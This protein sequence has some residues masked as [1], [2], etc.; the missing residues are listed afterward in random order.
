MKMLGLELPRPTHKD[1]L[2][3]VSGAL[4]VV[5]GFGV[6]STLIGSPL[7]RSGAIALFLGCLYAFAIHPLLDGKE[8]KARRV[9]LAVAGA[10][11][12][13][14]LAAALEHFAVL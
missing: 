6:G 5:V 9:A 1:A 13:V 3:A 14:A 8:A 12:L 4:A 2:V 11:L 10:C 7:D